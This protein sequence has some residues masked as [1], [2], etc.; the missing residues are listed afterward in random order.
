M[1]NV[2]PSSSGSGNGFAE[3]L[4][5]D[6][7]PACCPWSTGG[8][9]AF[10]WPAPPEASPE[11]WPTGGSCGGEPPFA[12]GIPKFGSS[13]RAPSSLAGLVAGGSSVASWVTGVGRRLLLGRPI[14]GGN[15][16]RRDLGAPAAVWLQRDHGACKEE[17]ANRADNAPGRQR[18][19]GFRSPGPV[20]RP[21]RERAGRRAES[22][23]CRLRIGREPSWFSC[24]Q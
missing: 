18:Q 24:R 23:E 4:S 19:R 15:T 17:K 7:S 13:P 5:G 9:S 2:A 11:R 1:I 12:R 22:T 10:A 6:R 20:L 8:F 21:S 3:P 14:L 16:R